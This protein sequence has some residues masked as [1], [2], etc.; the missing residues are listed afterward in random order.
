MNITY[1]HNNITESDNT[2]NSILDVIVEGTWDWNVN[3]GEVTRSPGWYKMLGYE[4]GIFL[5]NV[6]TWE[7]IIHPD[8][9]NMV[10]KHFELYVSG[11]IDTYEVEYRCKKSDDS[12]LWIV[13]RGKI[14]EYNEDGSAARMIG[15]HNNIHQR[16]MAESELITK[17]HLLREGNLSLEKLLEQK[18]R[19]L[20]YK[21]SQLEKKIK[22]VEYLSVTDTLTEIPN[23][24]KLEFEI[25]KEIARSSRYGHDLTFVIFDIDNFKIINDKYGHS[26][27]DNVL[28]KL[29]LLV[30]EQLRITDFIA[31]WGGEEFALILPETSLNQGVEVSQKLRKHIF[32]IEFEKDLFISC[33]FGVAQFTKDESKIDLFKRADKALYKA[34]ELGR[35]RVESSK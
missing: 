9:Y 30:K 7:N 18:N 16:K 17:N 32:Q 28:H 14:T 11:K 25:V 20:E 29:A 3:T 8:D 23:R 10:M 19:E 13:D 22:E 4:V 6:F 27:G 1:T 33:S 31:R 34:K 15:A 24:R 35:N 21:N 5:K 2:L 12:Y 26:I